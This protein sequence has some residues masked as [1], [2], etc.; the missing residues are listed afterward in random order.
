MIG[1]SVASDIEAKLNKDRNLLIEMKVKQCPPHKWK[2]VPA[3][4]IDGVVTRERISCEI[5]G[6]LNFTNEDNK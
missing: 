5:C 2:W 1:A 6:P 3:E 4:K